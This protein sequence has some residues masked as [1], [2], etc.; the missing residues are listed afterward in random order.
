MSPAPT[1]VVHAPSHRGTAQAVAVLVA[2][3]VGCLALGF[4]VGTAA[5]ATLPT[6]FGYRTLAVLSGSMEP[7]L[8]PGDAIVVDRISPLDARIGDIVTFRDPADQGR[9]ITHR[10][11]SY[12]IRAKTVSFVTRGD[13]NTGVERWQIPADGELGRAALRLP[14]LGYVTV[15]V[16]S[17]VG[18]LLLIA[19]P[20]F[21]LTLLA[22]R[23]IWASAGRRGGARSEA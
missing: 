20:A 14:K 23:R 3:T 18:R 4:A 21:L 7:A 6:A 22:L 5:V 11:R 10:V 9:L 2:R 8:H 1:A 17:R 16:G 15:R 12:S 13:A 19:L